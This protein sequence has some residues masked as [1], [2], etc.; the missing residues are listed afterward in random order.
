MKKFAIAMTVAAMTMAGAACAQTPAAGGAAPSTVISPQKEKLIQRILQL[1]HVENIGVVMLQ[2]P[3]A[4]SIRQSR[5][6]LQGRVS[7]ETQEAAMKDITQDAKKFMDDA[8]PVVQ[9]SALKIIPATVVPLLAEKFSEEELR[10]IVAILESPVKSKFEA[11]APEI[12]KALGEKI[13]TETG[14]VINP[15]LQKMTEEIGLRMRAA[16]NPQ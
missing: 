16:V 15:K 11:A 6:L 9:A 2:Q 3:V 5:S 4:E 8:T 13:A 14:P 1:W 7:T 12:E 10:Q